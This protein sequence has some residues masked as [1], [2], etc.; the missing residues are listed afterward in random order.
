MTFKYKHNSMYLYVYKYVVCKSISSLYK[1]FFYSILCCI[2]CMLLNEHD[3]CERRNLIMFLRKLYIC[4]KEREKNWWEI[5]CFNAVAGKRNAPL[6]NGNQ[7]KY[8]IYPDVE[9]IFIK[10]NP[11]HTFKPITRLSSRSILP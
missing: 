3:P 2:C 11:N 6:F 1:V 10:D 7:G 8:R 5:I 9:P 4:W